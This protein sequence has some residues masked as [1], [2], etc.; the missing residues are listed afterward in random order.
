VVER[1]LAQSLNVSRTPVREAVLRLQQEGFLIPSGDAEKVQLIVAPLEREAVLPLSQLAGVLEGLAARSAASAPL[2]ERSTIVAELTKDLKEFHKQL[3]SVKSSFLR[4][5]EIDVRF[6]ARFTDDYADDH[7]YKMLAVVRPHLARYTW[8][9]GTSQEVP[10][11]LYRGEH[12][13]IIDAI[14]EGDAELA[15]KSVR[16]NWVNTGQRFYAARL[17]RPDGKASGES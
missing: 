17:R 14:R 15:E 11:K 13:P 9:Y 7:L 4:L 10:W 8:A 5:Y 2:K 3:Q 16:A 1:A 6:H 12:V